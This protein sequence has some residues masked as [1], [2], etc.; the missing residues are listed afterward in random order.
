MWLVVAGA[1]Q[2]KY[3]AVQAPPETEDEEGAETEEVESGSELRVEVLQPGQQPDGVHVAVAAEE[4]EAPADVAVSAEEPEAPAVAAK[5]KGC[6]KEE[7]ESATDDD[8]EMEAEASSLG[9]EAKEEPEEDDSWEPE[10]DALEEA[11]L[12][13]LL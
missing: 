3:A 1:V 5:S 10:D 9:T 11:W 8:Q 12:S 13:V 6:E 4:P 7:P 2:R